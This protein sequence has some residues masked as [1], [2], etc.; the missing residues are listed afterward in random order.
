MMKAQASNVNIQHVGSSLRN[1]LPG[2][3]RPGAQIA[4]TVFRMTRD[5]STLDPN[6][7]VG[8]LHSTCSCLIASTFECSLDDEDPSML[9]REATGQTQYSILSLGWKLILNDVTVRTA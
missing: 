3:R 9:E 1:F 4:F 8:A 7:I 5:P 6:A 2:M